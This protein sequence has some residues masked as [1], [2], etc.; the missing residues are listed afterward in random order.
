MKDGDVL[1]GLILPP[2][3]ISKLQAELSTNGTE[4]ATVDVIVNNDDPLKAQLVDDRISSLLTQANLL[5][6]EKI[7][8]VAAELRADPRQRRR[9]HDPVPQPDRPHPRPAALRADPQ[10]RRANPA[11]AAQRSQVTQVSDFARLARQNLALANDLL[12]AVRRPSPST[13]R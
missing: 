4:P 8:G 11:A 12:A 10:L 7:S 9:V 5:I 13:S 3:F 1:G 2:D 6:S